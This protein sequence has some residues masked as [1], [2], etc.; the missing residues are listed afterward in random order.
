MLSAICNALASCLRVFE[1]SNIVL[2]EETIPAMHALPS[3]SIE[4]SCH[5]P[6]AILPQPVT[7][8]SASASPLRKVSFRTAVLY[9]SVLHHGPSLSTPPSIDAKLCSPK[10]ATIKYGSLRYILLLIA[11]IVF[12]LHPLL[13]QPFK[14]SM[15]LPPDIQS[16]AVLAL[17]TAFDEGIIPQATMCSDDHYLV[18]IHSLQ[19]ILFSH[20]MNSAMNEVHL[21]VYNITMDANPRQVIFPTV[22]FPITVSNSTIP[23]ICR[24]EMQPKHQQ[25][26][27][28]TDTSPIGSPMTALMT[29]ALVVL[30]NI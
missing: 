24:L 18:A 30:T 10:P 29:L 2:A 9:H 23:S 12:A 3:A 7:F 21:F 17:L 4:V 26:I 22:Q 27:P 20:P 8:L 25:A 28:R 16:N 1:I 11:L 14:P 6:S 19:S 15:L 5:K 13:E